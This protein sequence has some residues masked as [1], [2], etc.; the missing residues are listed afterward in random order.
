MVSFKKTVIVYGEYETDEVLETLE[1]NPDEYRV[2]DR[3]YGEIKRSASVGGLKT[4]SKK[5][6]YV[7]RERNDIGCWIEVDASELAVGDIFYPVLRRNWV[8]SVFAL[9]DPHT[10]LESLVQTRKAGLPPNPAFDPHDLRHFLSESAKDERK[11]TVT[12]ND[13]DLVF[14]PGLYNAYN[15]LEHDYAM[16]LS[17]D[18][19]QTLLDYV[20]QIPD[21]STTSAT[22][23]TNKGSETIMTAKDNII[24]GLKMGA[25]TTANREASKALCSSMERAGLPSAVTQD[26]TFQSV[27]MMVL[28]SL[29]QVAAGS[30]PLT[31]EQQS[32]LQGLMTVAQTSASAEAI[33]TIMTHL[34]D[35]V[36]P[37]IALMNSD[38]G[39]IE[40]LEG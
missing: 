21:G 28:P 23:T 5:T 2:V 35:A 24:A 38:S 27:I 12:A 8:P 30:L 7:L 15:A 9:P 3:M 13:W 39:T 6:A 16:V 14:R 1:L 29:V 18:L 40:Q 4:C 32:K 20:R 10:V 33:G 11:L 37:Y 31:S 22:S 25:I 26:P 17:L 34:G 19:N 36:K